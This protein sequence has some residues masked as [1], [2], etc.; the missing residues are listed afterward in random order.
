M[1]WLFIF[2]SIRMIRGQNS[3]RCFRETRFADHGDLDR[4]RVLELG[5]DALAEL[6]RDFAAAIVGY[7]L[8]RDDD[9][10]LAAG[11]DGEGLL[12]ALDR[13]RELLQAAEALDI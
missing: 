12:H 6:L 11:L 9:T 7:F 3:G 10:D 2:A 8:R 13:Q 4:A 5:L 1:F